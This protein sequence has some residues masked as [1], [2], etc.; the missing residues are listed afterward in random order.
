VSGLVTAEASVVVSETGGVLT[1]T[2]K[3]YGAAST[4]AITGGTAKAD[5]FGTP[6]ETAGVNVAGTIGNNT[7][8]GSG[9]VLTG[10]GDASGLEITVSGGVTGDRGTIK[11]ARGYAYELDKLAGKLLENDSLLDGRMDGINASIKDIGRKREQLNLRLE[12]IEKRYRAQFN[13]LDT[14]M[15][16]MQQTSTYLMQQLASLPKPESSD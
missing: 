7:A 1:M 16:R 8:T 4:V 11:F 6:V 14:L 9:Q 10:T 2:S 5:L 12:S 13:A 3:R 15:A